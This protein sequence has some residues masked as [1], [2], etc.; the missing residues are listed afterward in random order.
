M[1]RTKSI[2]R[3][4]FFCLCGFILVAKGGSFGSE[5]WMLIVGIIVA[6]Y[7]LRMFL[8]GVMHDRSNM[9]DNPTKNSDDHT[10]DS[11]YTTGDSDELTKISSD[12]TSEP[13]R[14]DYWSLLFGMGLTVFGIILMNYKW[15]IFVWGTALIPLVIVFEG[16]S[17]ILRVLFPYERYD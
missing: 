4:I 16:L 13:D 5:R 7:G 11:D 12:R 1:R 14:T 10:G 3:G 17:I 9:P 8:S 15:D 2:I 6:I